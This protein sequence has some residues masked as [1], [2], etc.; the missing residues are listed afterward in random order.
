MGDYFVFCRKWEFP[1][2]GFR[3]DKLP[4]STH[5]PERS[6]GDHG[7]QDLPNPPTHHDRHR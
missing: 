2:I 7:E 4:G 3:W 6:G 1:S 5:K